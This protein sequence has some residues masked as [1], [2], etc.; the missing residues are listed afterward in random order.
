MVLIQHLFEAK[1]FNQ[2]CHFCAAQNMKKIVLIIAI[3]E[4][5]KNESLTFHLSLKW[6]K[7][8]L[9]SSIR[10]WNDKVAPIKKRLYQLHYRNSILNDE[11]TTTERKGFFISLIV[12]GDSLAPQ[13]L[14]NL[15]SLKNDEI[16][17][18]VSEVVEIFAVDFSNNNRTTYYKKS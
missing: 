5:K 8:G 2:P 13:S 15:S 14:I 18:I 7:I 12:T 9:K 16:P 17:T 11:S 10:F 6:I 4:A 1:S 3:R